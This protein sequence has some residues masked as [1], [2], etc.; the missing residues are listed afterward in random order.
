MLVAHRVSGCPA[1]SSGGQG[2][3]S[4]RSPWAAGDA[5]PTVVKGHFSGLHGL[6]DP[7]I[8]AGLAGEHAHH[9][10]WTI[11]LTHSGWVFALCRP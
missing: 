11:V 6:D 2:G 9:S 10:D 3:T 5:V 1:K 8:A 7:L 4:W